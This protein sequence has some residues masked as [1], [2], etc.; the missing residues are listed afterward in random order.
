MTIFGALWGHGLSAVTPLAKLVA[1][2]LGDGCNT[3]A[4]GTTHMDDLVDWCCAPST[5]ITDALNLLATYHYVTWSATADGDLTYQL[6]AAAWPNRVRDR[7]SIERTG[8]IYIIRGRLGL[9]VGITKSLPRRLETLGVATLDDGLK[10]EWSIDLR[11]DIVR[12]AERRAH[13]KL[14]AKLVRNEWFDVSIEEAKT[15]VTTAI[16]EVRL[17][18][19]SSGGDR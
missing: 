14:A 10:V 16:E 1:I 3:E 5:E 9:K 4:I 13:Q 19:E 17:E 8:T 18:L 15:A 6:P 12:Q 11:M 2:R 7:G